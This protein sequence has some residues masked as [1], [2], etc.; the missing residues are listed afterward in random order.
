MST[1]GPKN[2]ALLG[3]AGEQGRLVE[4]RK[5][6]QI[7]LGRRLEGVVAKRLSSTYIPGRRC[8]AWVKHKLRRE[9]RLAVTGIRRNREG[10]VQAILVARRHSDGSFA[11]AGA[12]ELGL[13]RELIDLI[14]RRLAELPPHRCSIRA[15]ISADGGT[16]RLTA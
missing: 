4:A 14:E 2:G 3:A 9:E 11:G 1:T 12:I 5:A 13:H 15:S 10:H 7:E 8:T 16:V 6:I